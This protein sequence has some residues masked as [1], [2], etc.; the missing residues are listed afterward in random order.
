MLGEQLDW[1]EWKVITLIL[2]FL[3]R[4]HPL[5]RVRPTI[6]TEPLCSD[7]LLVRNEQKKTRG[8]EGKMR[9]R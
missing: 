7:V 2:R 3:Q 9:G 1:R 8:R 6:M 4:I 5:L